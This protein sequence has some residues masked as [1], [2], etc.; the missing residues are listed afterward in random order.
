MIVEAQQTERDSLDR[1][2]E[3]AKSELEGV[4]LTVEGIVDRIHSL[5]KY[6]LRSQEE[7]L[8]ELNVGHSEFDVIRVLR[9][10]GAP[11]RISP[12]QIAERSKV[13]SGAMTN[14]LDRLEEAGLV[15]RLPDPDDR[16]A[17]KIELTPAGHELWG[18]FLVAQ[19]AKESEI[20]A[21]LDPGEQAQLNELL[22]RLMLAFEATGARLP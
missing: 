11:Y 3:A 5:R 16:R 9:L 12:G 13:S 14:R 18:R 20:A 4:D 2:L 1:W 15:R 19:A 10:A 22:R 8:R 7:T 6:F 21:A 17:L